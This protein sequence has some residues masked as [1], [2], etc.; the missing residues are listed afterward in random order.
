MKMIIKKNPNGDT[1]TAKKHVT[2]EE[3]QEANDMHI[4][5]VRGVM[6]YL[7]SMIQNSGYY[8]DWTK[9]SEEKLFYDNFL[10]TMNEGTDFTNQKWYQYHIYREKHH[11]LSNCH[12]DVN[13]LDIIEMVVDCVC[14]GKARSGEIRALEISDDILKLA[15]NNTV[16]LIDSIT[17]VE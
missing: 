14:A 15:F 11:P 7:S 17:D 4:K 1:R 9:K 12:E 13:L 2:F 8:H 10:S 5:D 6:N 16:K 3:F